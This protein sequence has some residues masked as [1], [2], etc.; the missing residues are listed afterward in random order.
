MSAFS[1]P[2]PVSFLPHKDALRSY[3]PTEG[4]A[5]RA[6]TDAEDMT[7]GKLRLPL[8]ETLPRKERVSDWFPGD[9]A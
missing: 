5:L 3:I 4:V 8:S 6:H 9:R 7:L 1:H 2:A